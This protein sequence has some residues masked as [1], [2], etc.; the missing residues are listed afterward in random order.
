MKNNTPTSTPVHEKTKKQRLNGK[1]VLRYSP[2]GSVVMVEENE[3]TRESLGF[4]KVGT[5]VDMIADSCSWW[6]GQKGTVIEQSFFDRNNPRV[7]IQLDKDRII[8]AQLSDF[9]TA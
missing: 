1:A 2:D 9:R 8:G 6:R 7:V 5:R 4:P 3:G